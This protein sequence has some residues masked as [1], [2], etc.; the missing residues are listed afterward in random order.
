MWQSAAHKP[1]ASLVYA[2]AIYA[3][4]RPEVAAACA[5][6]AQIAQEVA[7]VEGSRSVRQRNSALNRAS[8]ALSAFPATLAA[9]PTPERQV[10]ER[11]GA[12]WLQMVLASASAVGTLE[13]RE[14]A[15]SPCWRSAWS[16]AAISWS[17]LDAATCD[18]TLEALRQHD[19]VLWEDGRCGDSV[20]LMRR[21]VQAG[22]A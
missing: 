7:L 18:A 15:A 17:G 8:G 13:V 19:V 12:Q 2:I 14:P 10:L 22:L 3:L 6:L 5:R 20:E 4:L 11:I 1:T 16:G 9:C 21:W